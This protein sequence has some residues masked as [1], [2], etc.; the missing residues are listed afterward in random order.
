MATAWKTSDD[1][2]RDIRELAAIAIED[3]IS[4][5]KID[6]YR[7]ELLDYSRPD[8]EDRIRSRLQYD[9]TVSYITGI[10]QMSKRFGDKLLSVITTYRVTL[11]PNL[12]LDCVYLMVED[13]TEQNITI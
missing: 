8:L 1:I 11:D 5:N 2:K 6:Y 7:R 3:K 9:L 13:M 10:N 4:K 12:I